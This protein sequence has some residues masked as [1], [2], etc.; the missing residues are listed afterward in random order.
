M[1]YNEKFSDNESSRIKANI[2]AFYVNKK[3]SQQ[4]MHCNF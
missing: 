4:G 3:N 2:M 1:E